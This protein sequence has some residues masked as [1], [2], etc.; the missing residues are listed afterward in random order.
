[1]FGRKKPPEPETADAHL[2]AAVRAAL[3][4]A[5]DDTVAIVSACAG[6]LASVAYADRE[7]SATEREHARKALATVSGIGPSG[8]EAI[9]RVL[10]AQVL[11]LSTVHATRFTRTLK[12]LGDRELRL[13]VLEM[14]ID[15]CASDDELKS[16]EVV[17]LRQTTS[18]LG[19][20]Q[21]DYNRLQ[22][23]HRDKLQR[24]R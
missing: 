1:M 18:A 3:P 24:A 4:G 9:A 17:L 6:L 19:L 16:Q 21:D 11:E 8:A 5:D 22:A 23:V 7:F 15:L 12:E 14:L 2:H 10:E 13:H 20:E